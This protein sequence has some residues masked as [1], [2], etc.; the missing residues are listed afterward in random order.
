M[1][2]WTAR[3]AGVVLCLCGRASGDPPPGY[4]DTIDAAN[5]TTLRTALH[6]VIDDQTRICYT[7]RTQIDS[8]DVLELAD[9]DPMDSPDG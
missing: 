7:H 1:N 9:E 3:L 4:F 8:W 6:A 2:K 5:S